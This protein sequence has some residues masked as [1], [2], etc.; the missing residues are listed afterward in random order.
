MEGYIIISP[1]NFVS[2]GLIREFIEFVQGI[3]VCRNYNTL[4]DI[5]EMRKSIRMRKGKCFPVFLI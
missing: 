3:V 5:G 4:V 2:T 1:G